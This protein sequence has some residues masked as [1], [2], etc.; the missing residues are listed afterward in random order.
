V[1]LE[2]Q[3]SLLDVLLWVGIRGLVPLEELETR[4]QSMGWS[5]LSQLGD[6][7]SLESGYCQ[8]SE[9]G[10]A[11]LTTLCRQ[12]Y[13]V[14]EKDTLELFF[15]AFERLD[16]E[17]KAIASKWQEIRIQEP[18]PDELVSVLE[19]W[20]AVDDNLRELMTQYPVASKVIGPYVERLH[21]ARRRFEGGE[22]DAFTG[23]NDD[24]Y[25][26][27]WHATHEVLLRALDRQRHE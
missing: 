24:S 16:R 10:D 14:A 27:V 20:F 4:L 9:K 18:D 11:H 22:T 5:G 21:D 13:D 12:R 17:F 23:I 1:T 26:T 15:D 7:V 19:K 3:D 6:W 25:H 2:S 8:L